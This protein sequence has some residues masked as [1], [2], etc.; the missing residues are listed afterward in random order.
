LTDHPSSP[1]PGRVA[2]RWIELDRRGLEYIF[3]H[4]R[5]VNRLCTELLGVVE[6]DDGTVFTL[7]PDDFDDHRAYDFEAGGLLEENLDWSR[8]VSLGSGQGTL[9]PV[10]DLA[11]ERASLILDS[12]NEHRGAVCICDDFNPRWSE[13]IARSA[14]TAF[15]VGNETYHRLS[16]QDGLDR[17]TDTLRMADAVW[18]GVAAVCRRSLL[19]PQGRNVEPHDLAQCAASV[20]ELSCTAYDREGFVAWRRSDR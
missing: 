19:V 10:A 6:R 17:V 16:V 18:H 1:H 5:G 13:E 12:L 8:A 14:P 3:E 15:G 2:I 11:A 9:M 20:V 4:L 7:I